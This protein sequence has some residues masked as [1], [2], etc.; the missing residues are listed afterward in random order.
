MYYKLLT[1][2]LPTILGVNIT[3]VKC[4]ERLQVNGVNLL[5]TMIT[6]GSYT[7]GDVAVT[8]RA[9]AYFSSVASGLLPMAQRDSPRAPT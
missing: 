3:P 6:V 7:L 2:I 1:L 4:G 8:Y 5:H 9:S